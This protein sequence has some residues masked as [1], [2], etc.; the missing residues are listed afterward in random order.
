MDKQ[1]LNVITI[2]ITT[3]SWLVHDTLLLHDAAPYETRNFT[4]GVEV[5]S[6]TPGDGR[7]FPKKGGQLI[8]PASLAIK[9]INSTQDKVKMHYIGTLKSGK[10][11]DSSRD[12]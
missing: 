9:L 1:P 12:R 2:I 8:S 11:F 4:Q 5:T 6:I 7:T 10:K 3:T